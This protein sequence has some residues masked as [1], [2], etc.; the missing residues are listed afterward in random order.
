MDDSDEYFNDAFEL[1][2]QALASIEE[3]E[4]RFIASTQAQVVTTPPSYNGSQEATSHPNH[5]NLRRNKMPMVSQSIDPYEDDAFNL[6]VRVGPD[7]GYVIAVEGHDHEVR[8]STWQP[9]QARD[10]NSVSKPSRDR[11][12]LGVELNAVQAQLAKLRESNDLMRQSLREAQEAQLVKTGEIAM[13]RDT[14]EKQKKEH[15][16]AISKAKLERIAFEK[17][18]AELQAKVKEETERMATNFAFRLRELETSTRKPGKGSVNGSVRIPH[19]TH[20]QYNG[21][22][23]P[24]RTSKPFNTSLV[25]END[26]NSSD[27]EVASSSPSRAPSDR[28]RKLNKKNQFKGFENAFT[29]SA[30]VITSPIKKSNDPNPFLSSATRGRTL[31]QDAAIQND[32]PMLVDGQDNVFELPVQEVVINEAPPSNIPSKEDKL[33]PME[34]FQR[35]L[36]SHLAPHCDDLTL[37]TLFSVTFP[38]GTPSNL[39]K[40]YASACNILLETCSVSKSGYSLPLQNWEN[41]VKKIVGVFVIIG[42][43]LYRAKTLNHLFVLLDL[44]LQ[45]VLIIP[46]MSTHFLRSPINPLSDD[47]VDFNPQSFM[48]LFRDI[49]QTQLVPSPDTQPFGK[50]HP[51]HSLKYNLT[52]TIL[53]LLGCFYWQGA[54]G[55]LEMGFSPIF[56]SGALYTLLLATQGQGVIKRT[57][58]LLILWASD[59]RMIGFFLSPQQGKTSATDNP[60]EGLLAIVN[61]LSVSLTD[62]I[63]PGSSVGG[64]AGSCF[65]LG[66]SQFV[67]SIRAIVISLMKSTGISRKFNGVVHMFI[68]TFGRLSWAETPEWLTP[69]GRALCETISELSM[70]LIEM[71]VPGPECDSLWSV[72]HESESM[73]DQGFSAIQD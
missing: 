8:S 56:K 61:Q 20:T 55:D 40:L 70:D 27:H 9:I 64:K 3:V 73:E 34:E 38:S 37:H 62:I 48:L 45:I 66:N 17:T 25:K 32:D 60:S 31:E 11:K 68:V 65:K 21:T 5:I 69:E 16:D 35:I 58:Q 29:Q 26:G 49:I 33:D 22:Q 41:G 50:R 67:W 30:P 23:T 53:N 10:H 7:G 59:E 13:L 43:I 72:W 51:T 6:N 18:K 28:Y 42:N 63:D 44:L 39:V 24:L 1:D 54:E 14:V 4:T 15:A 47:L 52:I 12:D 2:E 46:S 57:L 36:L 71:I 19:N